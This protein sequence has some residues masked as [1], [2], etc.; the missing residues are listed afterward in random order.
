MGEEVNVAPTPEYANTVS[1]GH[2]GIRPLEMLDPA[3]ELHHNAALPATAEG[4]PRP[5]PRRG[6]FAS[7]LQRTDSTSDAL[8]AQPAAQSV[9]SDP[10]QYEELVRTAICQALSRTLPCSAAHRT[11]GPAVPLRPPPSLPSCYFPAEERLEGAQV[12]GQ[13]MAKL[14][15]AVNDDAD[16][17]EKELLS[18]VADHL[19]CVSA[20][21]REVPET[22][23]SQE[24]D[25]GISRTVS[26]VL[27]PAIREF[28][29]REKRAAAAPSFDMMAERLT[30]LHAT[31][32][33]CERETDVSGRKEALK[34]VWAE[35]MG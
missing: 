21:L 25:Q 23:L 11:L 7:P 2:G 29:E 14:E 1:S 9:T 17:C 33:A 3:V 18:L 6:P 13:L 28:A 4:L 16:E 8:A 15:A 22:A 35:T 24:L 30:R 26:C 19:S 5:S 34:R 20:T 12:S 10:T 27:L 31:E 32:A